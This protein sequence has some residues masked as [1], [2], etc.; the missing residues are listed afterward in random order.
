MFKNTSLWAAVHLGKDYD[1]N[2]R[3]AKKKIFGKQRNNKRDWFLKF[4]VGIDNIFVQSN[5]SPFHC[6]SQRFL[7]FCNLFGKM[8]DDPESNHMELKKRLS[9]LFIPTV[10]TTSPLCEKKNSGKSDAMIVQ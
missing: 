5:L 1:V 4:E 10:D 3:F 8:G 2:L 7:R 9:L 6:Q